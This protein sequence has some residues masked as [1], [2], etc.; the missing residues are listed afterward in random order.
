IHKVETESKN[1]QK[2]VEDLLKEFEN[3]KKHIHINNLRSQG[4]TIINYSQKVKK[5]IEQ[6][7]HQHTPNEAGENAIAAKIKQITSHS[8]EVKNTLALLEDDFYIPL[9]E[10][11]QKMYELTQKQEVLYLLREIEHDLERIQELETQL[12]RVISFDAVFNKE[13]N[14]NFRDDLRSE[15]KRKEF[16]QEIDQLVNVMQ[17]EIVDERKNIETRLKK[18]HPIERIKAIFNLM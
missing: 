4:E 3:R 13:N 1:T 17:N 5:E 15:G 2:S 9:K 12:M 8:L 6:L 14:P 16:H 7:L 10:M 11:L 18:R